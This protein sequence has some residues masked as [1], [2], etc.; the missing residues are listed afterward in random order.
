MNESNIKIAIEGYN[1]EKLKIQEHL[2][3][4]PDLSYDSIY[5]NARLREIDKAINDLL[6]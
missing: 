1:A 3:A 4:L 5:L 2:R 6:S